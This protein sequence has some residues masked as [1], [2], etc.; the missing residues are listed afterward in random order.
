MHDI[1][2]YLYAL[3]AACFIGIGSGFVTLLPYVLDYES[4]AIR[5]GA[6]LEQAT[7]LDFEE[8]IECSDHPEVYADCY[9]A[10]YLL[11]STKTTVE[12]LLNIFYLLSSI[13][14]LSGL[15]GVYFHCKNP[16]SHNAQ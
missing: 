8:G 15:L 2:K 5:A 12:L 10:A 16:E 1:H 13:G 14:V 3:F 11:N 7:G 4:K 6:E 9:H